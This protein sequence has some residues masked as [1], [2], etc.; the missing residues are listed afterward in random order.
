MEGRRRYADEP[1]PL[2]YSGL[3]PY[4]S[5]PTNPYDS[6]VHE[7]PSGAFRLPDQRAADE[8]TPPP[9]SSDFSSSV[10]PA[11]GGGSHALADD[12]EASRAP[13][14]GTEYPTIRPSGATSLADAPPPI[15]P[16]SGVPSA[17]PAPAGVGEPTKMVPPVPDRARPAAESIYRIRRPVS[18]VIIALVT[19]ALTVPALM[20]LVQVTFVDHPAVRGIV[21]AVLLTIGVPLAG[22]GLTALTLGGPT[23][24]DVWLRPPVIY[25]PIG[26]LLLLAAAAAVA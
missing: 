5:Q 16:T 17:P 6:G 19:V 2:W 4:E 8:Y 1:E 14:R 24:R 12:T 21:P 7:R 3:G 18:A 23:G 20:L 26:L 15:R 13:V 11:S 25:L 10:E 22:G 9:Y